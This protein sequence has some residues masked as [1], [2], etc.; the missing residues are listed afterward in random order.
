M[1]ADTIEDTSALRFPVLVSYKLDGVRATMQGGELLSRNLKPI[2]NANVQKKFAGL[3]EGIDGEL[4][5]GD[6]TAK[7]EDGKSI[8]FRNTTPVVM[9]HNKPADDC[10]FYIFD[11]FSQEPFTERYNKVISGV[12]FARIP[13]VHIVTQGMVEDEESLLEFEATALEAGYEGVMVRDPHGPYK[14]GRST[15]KQGWLL[16]LKRFTDCE[17][18]ILDTVELMHNENEAKTN[19]LGRTQRSTHKAGLVP[20][21]VLGKFIVRDVKTGVVFDIGGGLKA[22]ERVEYWKKRKSMPGK[23]L[24]YSYFAVGVKDKPRFPVIIGFRDK[25]DM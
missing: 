15:V 6:P 17:C 9:S 1:L 10:A 3:P 7:D 11:R 14:E 21:G 13:D 23:F 18:E 16:K 25:A 5:V 24:K 20:G 8:A 19:E 12:N 22:H 4:I 2:K